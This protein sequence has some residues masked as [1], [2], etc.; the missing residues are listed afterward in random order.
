MARWRAGREAA[1]RGL[2]SVIEEWLEFFGWAGKKDD[3][4]ANGFAVWSRHR[5]VEVLAGRAA[6][7][8]VEDDCAVEDVGLLRVV[9]RHHH[10]ARGE[11]F[12]ESGEDGVV[13]VKADVECGGGG[14]AGE[15]VFGGAEAAGEDDDVGAGD[16][17]EGGAG[18][19][20][21]VVADDGLEGDLDAEVVE[22]LGEV[23]GVGVLAEGREHLGASCDDFSDHGLI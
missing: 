19:M 16:G 6:V 4:L 11:A 1:R 23:E 3:D 14:L 12:V 2:T 8:V 22:A 10:L 17:D 20:G 13:G 9:G 18:E 15:V 5:G 21:E 7:F